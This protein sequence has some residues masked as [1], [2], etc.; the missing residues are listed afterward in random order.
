MA[1]NS[2]ASLEVNKF[3]GAIIKSVTLPSNGDPL[4]TPK[5]ITYMIPKGGSKRRRLNPENEMDIDTDENQEEQEFKKV[6]DYNYKQITTKSAKEPTTYFFVL[7]D[8]CVAYNII[9]TRIPLQRPTKE[10]ITRAQELNYNVNSEVTPTRIVIKN[11][12]D[13][14]ETAKQQR[15]ANRRILDDQNSQSYY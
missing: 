4:S 9:K 2:D 5:L 15:E 12:N 8:E 10:D 14:S 7:K 3:K 1:E 13:L 11:L 6:R